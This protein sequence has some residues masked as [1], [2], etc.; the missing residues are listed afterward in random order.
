[1]P[2]QR[3]HAW[4]PPQASSDPG[5][6][7]SLERGLAILSSFTPGRTALGISELSRELSLTRRTTRRY[8]AALAQLGYLR[9]DDLTRTYR[10]GPR[11]LDLSFSMPGSLELREIAAPHLRRLTSITGHT[12][13]LAIRDDT[14]VILIDRVHSRPGRYHHLEFT[15]HA[16]SS[17]PAYCTATGKALLAFLPRPDL[18]RLL[19]RIDLIQRGPRTLTTKAA[20][21]T[22]LTQVRGT[23][24]AVN[25]EELDSALRSI[26]AP[27]RSQS[28][29]VIAAINIAIPW[30]PA[31]ISELITQHAPVIQA[32]ARRIS[33]QLT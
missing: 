2:V 7:R 13:N 31:A 5:F 1:M 27:I 25:D 24:I 33:A 18:D 4:D 30:S 12:S 6:S 21:L 3:S 29:E 10:L 20:L 28:G 17:L 32:T 22:E 11:V 15:L 8:A 26:A 9:H 19:D 16:G 23:G 14:D